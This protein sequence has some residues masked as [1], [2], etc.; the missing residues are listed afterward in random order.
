MTTTTD[1]GPRNSSY[2]PVRVEADLDVTE[3]R[4]VWLFKWL[5]VIPHYVLLFFLWVAFLVLSVVAFFAILFTGRYPRAIFD[6]NV[7]VLRWS[8]R[9]SYY[10][11]GALGTD[12]YPPFRLAEAPEYPTHLSI[13]YPERLSRGLVLV[14][15]WLLAIPHYLVVGFL[16]GGGWFA[17]R[18]SSR[19]SDGPVILTGGLIGLL[20]LFAGVA[21]LFTG[22]YP[23]PLFDL[24]LGLN[25]WVL[26]VAAYVALMTDVYPPFRLDQGGHEPGATAEQRL[27]LPTDGPGPLPGAT[28]PFATPPA[29]PPTPPAV[30]PW[31]AGRI[32][33]VVV[34][35]LLALTGLG[36]GA[37]GAAL[38]VAEAGL[39]DDNGYLTSGSTTL[40]TDTY[41]LTSGNLEL[42]ASG[43]A[44]DVPHQL[45]GDIKFTARSTDPAVPVFLGIAQTSDVER[46]L[47]G[48][49][50][51]T[52]TGITGDADEPAYTTT[53]GGA[54]TTAPSEQMFWV[55]SNEG[56]G[57]QSMTWEPRD[58]D[59]TLVAMPADGTRGLGVD[60]SV[61]ATLPVLGWIAA[62]LLVAAAVA[63]ALGILLVLL[64]L[65]LRPRPGSA[66]VPVQPSGPWS[67]A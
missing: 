47:E 34:G 11:Y 8:W 32:V 7:G 59:W 57:T 44:S 19:V 14:K 49:E 20:V 16:L 31:T 29:T 60:V 61:A 42:H 1:Q 9:V 39:R 54:P 40:T 13:D 3:S 58:G 10:A 38:G 56:R 43:A 55:A 51:D 21:L 6:F 64:A 24:V 37:G 45:L 2:S 62:G 23:R 5:L 18:E 26:R 65:T 30:R 63:L 36:L 15:W 53:D 22:R 41:A 46:Y 48:V 12:R 28:L 17:A 27:D 25:R 66:V 50:R 67:S 52:V 35:S 4:W 33:T